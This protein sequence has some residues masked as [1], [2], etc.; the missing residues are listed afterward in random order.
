MYMILKQE[1]LKWILLKGF[2]FDSKEKYE[3]KFQYFVFNILK[4][5]LTET[6]NFTKYFYIFFCYRKLYFLAGGGV[7][8][9]Y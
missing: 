9:H 7:H 1:I 4:I 5:F 2:F 3:D 8:F 6:Q